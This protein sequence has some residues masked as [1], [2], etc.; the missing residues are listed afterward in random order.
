MLSFTVYTA[1]IIQCPRLFI[2]ADS[3]S[4]SQTHLDIETYI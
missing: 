2:R 4:L 3:H 1:Q